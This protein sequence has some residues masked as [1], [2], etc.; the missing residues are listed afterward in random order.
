MVVSY[1]PAGHQDVIPYLVV[2]RLDR[3]LAFVTEAFGAE[4]LET[5]SGPGDAI[6][7][8][9]VRIRDSVV[10][11]GDPGSDDDSSTD[12]CSSFR[13]GATSSGFASLLLEL[14]CPSGCCRFR[15][16]FF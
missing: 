5:I 11:M 15:D 10:M 16:C 6:Q 13:L 14:A 7:H 3:V 9:E 2:R 12:S 4:V 1:K 8:V